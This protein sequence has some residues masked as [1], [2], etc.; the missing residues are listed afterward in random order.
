MTPEQI[1]NAIRSDLDRIR[2]KVHDPEVAHSYEDIL[3][4]SVLSA[5]ADGTLTGDDAKECAEL[6]LQTIHIDFPRWYA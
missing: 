5:I 2:Q 3:H 4:Q 6:A 1:R